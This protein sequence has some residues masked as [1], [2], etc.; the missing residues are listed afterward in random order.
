MIDPKLV[1]RLDRAT[2][3]EL[4]A[5]NLIIERLLSDPRRILPTKVR[6]HIGQ[7]VQY[8]DLPPTGQLPLARNGRV[9][10]LGVTT[11]PVH[12]DHDRR[13]WKLPYGAI[14]GSIDPESSSD[15]DTTRKEASAQS[16]PR[17]SRADFAPG[18]RVVFDDRY[19][20]PKAGHITRLNTK[21]ATVQCDDGTSWRVGYGLLR[22]LKDV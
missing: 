4:Y 21:T 12:A 10:E 14:L 17:P 19:F 11:V 7:R 8:V 1:E 18:Q 16:A 15:T 22:P 3:E 2:S 20:S 5:L 6:L 9:I 13:N